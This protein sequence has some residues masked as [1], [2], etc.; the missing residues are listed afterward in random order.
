MNRESFGENKSFGLSSNVTSFIEPF[1]VKILM[2][3]NYDNL[4]LIN[5]GWITK[6]IRT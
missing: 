1:P 5:S 2:N 4:I 6:I 3:V